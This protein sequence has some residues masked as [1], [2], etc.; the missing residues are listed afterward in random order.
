MTVRMAEFTAA[1]LLA[2]GSIGLMWK[3]TDG[4]S[5][6]WIPGNGPGSGFW[7]FWLSLI[8]LLSSLTTLYRAWAGKTPQSRSNEPFIDRETFQIVGVT[9][10]ALFFLLLGTSYIGLYLSL[11]AFLFFYLRILG[12]HSWLLTIALMIGIPVF[13][14]MF[15]EIL[16]TVPLPKGISEPLFY[17]IYDL[18]Y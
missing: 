3:S 13:I 2:L 10:A 5:I 9:V 18:M 7:P 1:F 14:F 4:L 11:I 15:F 16:M 17:P 6:G 8:M 12:G